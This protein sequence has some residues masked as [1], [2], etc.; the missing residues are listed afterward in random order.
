MTEVTRWLIGLV[1]ISG[2]PALWYLAQTLWAQFNSGEVTWRDSA[3]TR[4]ALS[5]AMLFAAL[6]CFAVA[7]LVAPTTQPKGIGSQFIW[8]GWTVAWLSGL[9]A[10]SGL[11]P[12]IPGKR[13]GAVRANLGVCALWT[14]G[15]MTWQGFFA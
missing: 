2:I 9:M 8:S 15:F 6:A 5:I 10:I 7:A 1:C 13:S 3:P 4:L 11:R 12:A 14:I